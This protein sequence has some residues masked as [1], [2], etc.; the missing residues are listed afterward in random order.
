M[1]KIYLIN[2]YTNIKL[3]IIRKNNSGPLSISRELFTVDS[4][5]LN[6]RFFFSLK[7]LTVFTYFYVTTVHLSETFINRI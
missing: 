2:I 7:S 6:C 3:I 5:E 4:F 1:F